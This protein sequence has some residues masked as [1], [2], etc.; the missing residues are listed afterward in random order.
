M[1]SEYA[2]AAEMLARWEAEAARRVPAWERTLKEQNLDPKQLLTRA[3]GA[4][5]G[6]DVMTE[7]YKLVVDD[8]ALPVAFIHYL[9][10]RGDITESD[11]EIFIQLVG[12]R[13]SFVEAQKQARVMRQTDI[14][15]KRDA[16]EFLAK[17]LPGSKSLTPQLVKIFGITKQTSQRYQREFRRLQKPIK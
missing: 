13:I 14:K 4:F 6:R 2:E 15:N 9:K 11:F 8:Y 1:G 17:Q 16:F 7:Q 3:A 10:V 12:Q 5:A